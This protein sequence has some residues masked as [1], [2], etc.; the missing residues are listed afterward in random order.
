MDGTN[1]PQSTASY[2]QAELQGHV[3]TIEARLDAL[4]LKMDD[5]K[6]AQP[7]NSKVEAVRVEVCNIHNT[8]RALADEATQKLSPAVQG[9][10]YS[11][12]TGKP[13]QA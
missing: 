6:Q 9:P 2:T 7:A 1:M 5:L 8:L 3:S 13:V 11:G 12:G 4:H 10:L